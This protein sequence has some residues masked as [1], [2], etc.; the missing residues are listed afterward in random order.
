MSRPSVLLALLVLSGLPGAAFAGWWE[1]GNPP[2]VHGLHSAQKFQI[3]GKVNGIKLKATHGR[4]RVVTLP[5]PVDLDQAL[6]LPAGEW[7][8][9][10]LLLDGPLTV[11]VDGR[12]VQ[13]EVDSLTVVLEDPTA[14][15]VHL[16][17][18]LP[19]APIRTWSA[20][21]LIQALEDGAIARP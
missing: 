8:E 16:E 3:S 15:L 6:S 14:R 21:A 12:Q 1:T 19:D 13:L 5:A 10:T 20:D 4:S 7:A 2:D 18:S 17:W 9:V 11:T